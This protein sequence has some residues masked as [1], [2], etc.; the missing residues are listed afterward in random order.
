MAENQLTP[1]GDRIRTEPRDDDWTSLFA[2]AVDDLTRIVHSEFRLLVAGMKAVLDEEIDR[3]LAFMVTGVLM[4]VGALCMIAA[5]I[6]FLHEFLLLP[7]W[8]SFGITA[9]AM[10]AIAIVIRATASRRPAP[11]AIT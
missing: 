10:F 4:M 7:W 9:L 5:L 8:Q 11:P 2:R 1:S 6:M 3:V